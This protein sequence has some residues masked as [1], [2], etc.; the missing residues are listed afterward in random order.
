MECQYL[1]GEVQEL[2]ESDEGVKITIK[3]DKWE[4][5][6][7]LIRGSYHIKHINKLAKGVTVHCIFL[8]GDILWKMFL[9][10]VFDKEPKD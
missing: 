10:S 5:T 7:T 8:K 3:F 9:E 2:Q 1:I 4:P 6:I